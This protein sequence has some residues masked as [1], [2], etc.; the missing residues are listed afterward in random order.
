METYQLYG[1]MFE[2]SLFVLIGVRSI[3]GC[4]VEIG[5]GS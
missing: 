5:S 2:E 3:H 1:K 4:F